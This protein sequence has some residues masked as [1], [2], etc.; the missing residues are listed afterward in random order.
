MIQFFK[1]I[2]KALFSPSEDLRRIIPPLPPQKPIQELYR[3]DGSTTYPALTNIKW[4]GFNQDFCI[5][6]FGDKY[7]NS[8]NIDKITEWNRRHGKELVI[9]ASDN[10]EE[11]LIKMLALWV[12]HKQNEPLSAEYGS[13]G[14]LKEIPNDNNTPS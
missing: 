12:K 6:A 1:N 10:I 4:K 14:P 3:K 13:S 8:S 9:Y 2:W 7:P 5:W 11:S